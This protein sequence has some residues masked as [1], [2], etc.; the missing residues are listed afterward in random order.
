[1]NALA[2]LRKPGAGAR[3]TADRRAFATH[4]AVLPERSAFCR[5]WMLRLDLGDA[6]AG[7]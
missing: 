4:E 2:P 7:A 1:M 3:A 5:G 6:R